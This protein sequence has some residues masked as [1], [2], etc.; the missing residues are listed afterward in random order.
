MYELS[1]K[2]VMVF[3]KIHFNHRCT[4]SLCSCWHVVCFKCNGDHC[5]YFS[6]DHKFT[7]M[8]LAYYDVFWLFLT[9][10]VNFMLCWPCISI[11]LCNKNQLI[12]LFILS[13]FR[14]STSTCFGR[15]CS[16]SSGSTLYLYNNWYILYILV[17]CLLAWPTDSQLKRTPAS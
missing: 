17:D 14:Q 5:A 1:E 3:R 12:A 15:I 6:W 16:P 9:L 10:R 13:L 8:C 4:I 11:Y 2:Q 7:P